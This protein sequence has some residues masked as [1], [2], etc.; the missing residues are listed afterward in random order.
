MREVRPLD[1]L[2]GVNKPPGMTSHDVVSLVRRR[3]QVARAGHTG[4]LDPLAAGVL[5]VLLGRSTR[6]APLLTVL[7]KSYRATVAFG[8]STTTG[9]LGGRVT[10]CRPTAGMDPAELA[11]GLAQGLARLAGRFRQRPPAFSA[12]RVDGRRLYELARRGEVDDASLDRASR[13]VWVT[14]VRLVSLG[15]L[16]WGEHAALPAAVIDLVCSAG[17]YVRTLAEDLGTA[18]GHPACLAFLL[19]TR[20]GGLSLADCLTIEQVCE[21]GAPGGAGGGL[22]SYPWAWRP[23]AQAVSHLPGAVIRP[24]ARLRVARGADLGEA[25]LAGWVDPSADPRDLDPWTAGP[26]APG[27]GG[28]MPGS[29]PVRLLDHRGALLGL[30]RPAEASAGGPTGRPDRGAR[31]CPYRVFLGEE[32]S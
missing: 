30:A 20:A 5:P 6:L 26:A 19:R 18:A 32:T 16:G 11:Q 1:G 10:A 12:R 22:P 23:P 24:E 14:G 28:A 9:D 7:A 31:L 3:W 15:R 8:L 2:V 4:T 25:D 27:P 29:G 21:A 17:T 13:E